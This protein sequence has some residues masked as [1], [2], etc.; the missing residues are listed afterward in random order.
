MAKVESKKN[1][2]NITH[3]LKN[4]GKE[5]MIERNDDKDVSIEALRI[6]IDNLK[7]KI[8]D[9]EETIEDLIQERDDVYDEIYEVRLILADAW[10][11][12][13]AT[14]PERIWEVL[15]RTRE[16]KATQG[17]KKPYIAPVKSSDN[18]IAVDATKQKSETYLTACS[19]NDLADSGLGMDSLT[20]LIDE[21]INLVVDGKLKKWEKLERVP[22]PKKYEIEQSTLTRENLDQDREQNLI[23]H[24]LKEG[25]I[26][27]TKLV[28]DIFEATATQHKPAQI[29]RLGQRNSDK[30]RPLMLH[31]KNRDEKEEFMSKLWMLK[32]VRARFGNISITHDYTL[33]ERYL[34]KKWVAEAEQRNTHGT[35]EYRWKVRGTPRTGLRLVKIG[36]QE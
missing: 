32:N 30:T 16:I 14:D 22:E 5:S 33:E 31:M 24:G 29:M 3:D 21:R 2:Q 4:N 26:C 34:I 6:E 25:D 23:I 17:E 20:Q 18:Q 35:N 36:S 9:Q 11:V 7:K 28:K 1:N 10:N 8:G 12:K 27:D 13:R 19:S 15:R